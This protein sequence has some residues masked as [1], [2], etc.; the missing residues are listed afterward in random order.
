MEPLRPRPQSRAASP[1]PSGGKWVPPLCEK[2]MWTRAGD[3]TSA[4]LCRPPTT[5]RS[6]RESRLIWDYA[7]LLSFKLVPFPH[8]LP[9]SFLKSWN[10]LS[11]ILDLPY[12]FLMVSS[13]FSISCKLQGQNTWFWLNII[14]KNILPIADPHVLQWPSSAGTGSSL[15][16]SDLVIPHSKGPLVCRGR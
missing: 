3:T 10:Q 15:N 8:L 11:H 9:F 14:Y 12:C 1:D 4:S 16:Q 5:A 6:S 2:S 13:N 7:S